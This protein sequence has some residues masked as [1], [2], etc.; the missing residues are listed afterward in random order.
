MSMIA[1]AMTR[2]R[3]FYIYCHTAPNGKRYIGQ[4]CS[5]PEARWEKG[6]GYRRSQSYFYNAIK[7][8]GWDNF[9]HTIL[10]TCSSKDNA[11]FLERWFIEKYDTFNRDHGYNRTKG[12]GGALGLV[13][14][15]ETKEKLRQANLG[16]PGH[17]MSEASRK[18]MSR[19]RMGAGNPMFGKHHTPEV[20][21]RMS[22]SRTGRTFSE[23]SRRAISESRLKS[24]LIKR[25]PVYQFTF[26]GELVG[27]YESLKIA[28]QETGFAAS[29]IGNCCRGK[30]KQAYGYIWCYQNR[31]D[32]FPKQVRVIEG[33]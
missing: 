31:P 9:K 2:S 15:E 11:D 26:D 33:G 3:T 8:Y 14:T 5:K 19:E 1:V 17:P 25:C 4:T 20:C 32:T 16:K 24:N 12:G 13:V 27:S 29:N 7:K 10:C 18:K 21:A 30:Y 6:G 23:K 22:A 28:Q